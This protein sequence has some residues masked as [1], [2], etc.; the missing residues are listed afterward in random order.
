MATGNEILVL[1]GTV[2]SAF[3]IFSANR[4]LKMRDDKRPLAEVLWYGGG[5]IPL[6]GVALMW[7]STG[8]QMLMAQRTVLFVVGAI[9][10]GCALLVAGE[11]LR[12][13]GP[14]S[15]QQAPPQSP[16]I[17]IQGPGSAYSSGQT[18]GVTAGTYINQAPPPDLKMLE[19]KDT[20]NPDG[21]HTRVI[22][23]GV[24]SAYMP[25]QLILSAEAAGIISGD[26]H[27]MDAGTLNFSQNLTSERYM[28]TVN[29][30]T[31]RY[32][33]VVQT[34]QHEIINVRYAFK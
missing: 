4:G 11:L 25:G 20:V 5:L 29:G 24:V 14:V 13:V 16:D 19:S 15:A 17:V 33:L 34:K 18:G 27:P 2:S 1:A 21:T 30:P 12:P 8:D 22:S 9:I 3:F 10:G 23:L 28:V 26:I 7:A 6:A 32:A 31:G